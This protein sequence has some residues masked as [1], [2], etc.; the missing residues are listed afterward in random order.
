MLLGQLR[1]LEQHELITFRPQSM[2]TVD[3]KKRQLSL[4]EEHEL[5]KEEDAP[6]TVAV[7]PPV[8]SLPCAR[9][10]L[11]TERLMK[12]CRPDQGNGGG[13]QLVGC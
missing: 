2:Y 1:N 9:P 8:R 5:S 12:R 11:T 6:M 13:Y 3:V 4:V 7:H 10:H